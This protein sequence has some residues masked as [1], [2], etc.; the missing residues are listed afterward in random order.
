[1]EYVTVYIDHPI[2]TVKSAG[3]KR[4][5]HTSMHPDRSLPQ[6]EG[7]MAAGGLP[8]RAILR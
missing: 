1:M 8:G 7:M 4:A 3:M 6:L 5:S 2:A